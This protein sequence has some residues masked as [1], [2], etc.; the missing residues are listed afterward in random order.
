M[1]RLIGEDENIAQRHVETFYVFTENLNVEQLEVVL[2]LFVQSLDGEA[3][4]WFKALS[5]SSITAW[6]ELE[7]SFTQKWGE[8]R[9]HEYVLTE[10]NSIR[11]KLEE[12]IL[13]F[14]KRFNKKYN[15]LPSEIKPPQATTRVVFVGVFESNFGFTIRERKS[16]TL[17]QL[18][19]DA[20]EVEA[21]FTSA[22]NSRGKDEPTEKERGKKETSSSSKA[23][24]YLD[25]K[26]EEMDKL[27]KSLSHK[28]VKLEL[29]N[30]SLPKSNAQGNNRG[31]N[32]Q[33]IRPPL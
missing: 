31:Y 32:P 24:E 29:E 7:N 14:I 21:N 10:F 3:R 2:R 9:N 11:K 13:E 8:N 1:P 5:D 28:V 30:K 23:K 6:E 12:D 15:N 17:D 20:L 25:L 18:Q 22:G 4:K 27:I 33:Y 19:V 26:W 16:H